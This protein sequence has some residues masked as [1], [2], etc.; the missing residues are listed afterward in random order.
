MV[1]TAILKEIIY[2]EFFQKMTEQVDKKQRKSLNNTIKEFH[3]LRRKSKR[4]TL[5]LTDIKYIL[6]SNVHGTVMKRS[7][8]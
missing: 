6:F 1:K 8:R 4:G 7:H 2:R 5:S 3:L